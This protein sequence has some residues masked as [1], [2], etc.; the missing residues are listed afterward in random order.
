MA[1]FLTAVLGLVESAL[2]AWMNS[3]F[4]SMTTDA[5]SIAGMRKARD[6]KVLSTGVD[7]DWAMILCNINVTSKGTFQLVKYMQIFFH[8]TFEQHR[9]GLP[10]NRTVNVVNN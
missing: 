6:K 4:H 9:L 2:T 1:K 8:I 10:E 5:C 7:G 3:R